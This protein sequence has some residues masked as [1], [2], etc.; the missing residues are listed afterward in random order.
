MH[1]EIV[2]AYLDQELKAARV[3]LVGSEE[4]AQ[5]LDIHKRETKQVAGPIS[6][7]REKC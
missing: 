5:H 3:A 1:P 4:I 7:N 2:T 6:T